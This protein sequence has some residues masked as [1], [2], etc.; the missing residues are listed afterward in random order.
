MK[1]LNPRYALLLLAVLAFALGVSISAILNDNHTVALVTT[2]ILY[3]VATSLS[4]AA[5]LALRFVSK[6]APMLAMLNAFKPQE[7]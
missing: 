6:L 1:H 2:S 3:S 7:D 5:L 4:V